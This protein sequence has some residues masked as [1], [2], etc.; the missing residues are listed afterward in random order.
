MSR[1]KNRLHLADWYS[2]EQAWNIF[3]DLCEQLRKKNGVVGL[4]GFEEHP[5]LYLGSANL[6]PDEEDYK[7]DLTVAKDLWWGITSAAILHGAR[8]RIYSGRRE[9]VVL[10]RNKGRSFEYI[11]EC[12]LESAG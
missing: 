7:L 11:E 12:L 8:F 6:F 9:L 4:I 10:F 1:H 2:T 3:H 5:Y